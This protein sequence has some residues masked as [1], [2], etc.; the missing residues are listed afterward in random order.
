MEKYFLLNYFKNI[1][2]SLGF[3]SHGR[4]GAVIYYE[5][6]KQIRFYMEF[7]GRDEVFYLTIPNKTEWEEQTGFSLSRRE[8]ILNY[9]AKGTLEKQAPSSY[10]KINENDIVFYKK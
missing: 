1:F 4:E 2:R 5:G 7:G 3:V 9:V 10:Y 6:L 8:E